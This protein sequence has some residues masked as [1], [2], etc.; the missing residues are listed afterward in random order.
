MDIFETTGLEVQ[1]QLV[2]KVSRSH[3]PKAEEYLTLHVILWILIL[4]YEH[5]L[6]HT[7]NAI[8][9]ASGHIPNDD[10]NADDADSNIEWPFTLKGE[11]TIFVLDELHDSN[12]NRSDSS[13]RPLTKF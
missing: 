13:T 8:F 10:G 12:R 5:S 1:E 9:L 7:R 3:G 2:K 6:K 11:P 4:I